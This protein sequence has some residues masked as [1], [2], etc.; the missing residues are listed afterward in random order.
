MYYVSNRDFQMFRFTKQQYYR[1][2]YQKI[3]DLKVK[4]EIDFTRR[5]SLI[6]QI[7]NTKNIKRE[8]IAIRSDPKRTTPDILLHLS[9]AINHCDLQISLAQ[10]CLIDD[11]VFKEVKQEQVSKKSK[12]NLYALFDY[13]AMSLL[14]VTVLL[15]LTPWR[16]WAALMFL[17]CI[18]LLYFADKVKQ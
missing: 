5:N 6:R 16:I 2:Y 17:I 15:L 4:S 11:N 9:F 10:K 18:L 3:E 12:Q 7:K 8:L 14:A 1:Y 13:G